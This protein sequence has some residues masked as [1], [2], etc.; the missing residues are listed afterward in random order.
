MWIVISA[1]VI[2]S[3]VIYFGPQTK[4][5]DWSPNQKVTF[6]TVDGRP[7]TRDLYLTAMREAQLRYRVYFGDWPDGRSRAMGFDSE[8][9]TQNRV[10]MLM[11]MEDLGIV[12]DEAG[13]AEWIANTFRDRNSKSFKPEYYREFLKNQLAPRGYSEVDMQRFI[14][15]ELA[16]QHL[17]AL[18]G[19]SGRLVTPQEAEAQFRQQNEEVISEAVFFSATNFASSINISPAAVSEYFTNRMA[20]YRIPERVQV[21]EVRFDA[22]DFVAEAARQMAAQADLA[23]RIDAVYLERGAASFTDADGK[24]LPEAKAKEKLREDLKADLAFAEAR[25]AA[26]RFAEELFNRYTNA[27]G[28]A[29]LA[30]ERKLSVKSLEPF[31]R[32]GPASSPDRA[33]LGA[34]AF[35]LTAEEPFSSPI[36]GVVG[37]SVSVLSLQGRLPSQIPTLDSIRSRVTDDFRNNKAMEAARAAAQAFARN[38]AVETGKGKTLLDLAKVPRATY[39]RIPPFSRST[40]R[41]DDVE[42]RVSLST[43]KDVAFGLA[44]GKVS[45]YTPTPEGGMILRLESRKPVDEARLKAELPEFARSLQRQRQFDAFNEWFRKESEHATFATSSGSSSGGTPAKR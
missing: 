38:A 24:P 13:V 41:L 28:L 23:S 35:K 10:L 25:R 7:V 31:D 32:S 19:L 21:S 15:H 20:D 5:G 40:S 42:R 9:E 27:A 1:I 17:V 43:L 44:P 12:A 2:I 3:F 11:K 29:L 16:M 36:P 34:A 6:G 37:R 4:M 8:R 18:G 30:A 39:L 26:G 33:A 22:G 14:E 45:G